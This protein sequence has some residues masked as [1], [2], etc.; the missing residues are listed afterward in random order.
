M[1]VLK[2]YIKMLKNAGHNLFYSKV[3]DF[4]VKENIFEI[5]GKNK[6]TKQLKNAGEKAYLVKDDILYGSK[7]EIPLY[8]F[9]FLY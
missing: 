7:R 8:F 2:K 6:S 4:E 9:G 1:P 5:G 3:G